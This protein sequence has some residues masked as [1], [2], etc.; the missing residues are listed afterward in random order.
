M[1]QLSAICASV[2][3]PVTAIG[4]IT[5]SNVTKLQ[6]TG[7]AGISVVSGIFGEMDIPRAVRSLKDEVR[8]VVRL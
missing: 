2:P 1:V 5:L 4:G 7:I 8:K 6:G 3:I